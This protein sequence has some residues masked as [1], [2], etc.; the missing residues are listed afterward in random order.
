M[1]Y[2]SNSTTPIYE[3]NILFEDN[4][5]EYSVYN[6]E[7]F[8][9]VQNSKESSIRNVLIQDNIIRHGGYGWG[10]Y[11]R[12]NKNKGTNVSGGCATYNENFVYKNNIFD[13]SKSFLLRINGSGGFYPTFEGNTFAQKGDFRICIWDGKNYGMKKHGEEALNNVFKD[14]TG[15]LITY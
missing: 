11:S 9:H 7:Y 1:Q 4:L 2:S 15:K 5:F 3:E 8:Y 6:I 10:Y 13:H 14:L 12:P